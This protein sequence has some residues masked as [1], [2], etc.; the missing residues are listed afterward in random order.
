MALTD[1]LAEAIGDPEYGS[2]VRRVKEIAARSLKEADSGAKVLATN[3][4]NHSYLPDFVLKWPNRRREERFVFLRASAYAEELEEDVVRLA[5]RHPVFLQLSD[6]QPIDSEPLRPAIDSLDH[7]A[8][9]SRSLVAT[10]PAIGHLD[11]SPRTGRMLS[12][13]V[14][15]GGRGVIENTEAESISARVESGF[16]GAMTSDRDKTADA[17]AVV[18]GVLDPNSTADFTR[19]FEAA[20]ISGGASSAD[21]PGGQTTIG[22]E[23]SSDLLEQLLDIVPESIEDF[24]EKIGN[25]VNLDAFSQLHLV[26]DQP[27]LQHIMRSAVGRLSAT[28]HVFRRTERY[29]ENDDPF[30]W[31]VDTGHLSLRGA[32]YQG[33]I[34]V[35]APPTAPGETQNE[36]SIDPPP[37]LSSLSTRAQNANI[38]V[39]DISV[40]GPDAISVRF[41]SAGPLDVAASDLFE[42]VT[43]SLGDL[44]T[45]EGVISRVE[46]KSLAIDY[47][48][49]LATTGR[50]NSRV[51]VSNLVWNA[52]N[53]Q[54]AT[55]DD[56]RSELNEVLGVVPQT[57]PAGGGSPDD[58][59]AHPQKPLEVEGS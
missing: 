49:G 26:G 43:G 35:S 14:M 19:L 30:M 27:R 7:S 57:P 12:S 17:L 53:L 33:W 59:T 55:S 48:Q 52:W 38:T 45:V 16:N 32:G 36:L 10:M 15:R 6:F 13:F 18:E 44:V 29:G 54:A 40:Q 3:H 5:D 21:F 1:D 25:A 50:S 47:A 22:E 34:E 31:Q 23:L 8:S 46:G 42:R 4:F 41:S 39:S 51:S 28:K 56:I 37:S 24:W 11:D 2:S 58:D 9:E 20:W